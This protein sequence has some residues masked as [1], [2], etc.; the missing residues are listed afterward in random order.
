MNLLHR[1]LFTLSIC[2]LLAPSVWPQNFP[3]H[4]LRFVI[5]FAPG[6]PA[7]VSARTLAVKLTETLGQNIVIDNRPGGGGIVAAEI[8]ARARP[9][10]HTILLCSTSVMVINP[11]V[12]PDVPYD[13]LRDFAPVSLV[14]SSPYLLLTHA[15]FPATSVKELV[16]LAK[17]RP[18][19]LNFGSAGIGSTSHL[20]AEIFRSMAGIAMTHVPYKG[21]AL[22]ATDLMAGQLQVLFE[23]VSSALPNVNS[24]RLRALGISTLKRFA[25]T[26]QVPP[27]AESGVPGYQAATWQGVCAPAGTPK[28]VLAVLNRTVVDAARAPATVQRYAALGAEAVGSTPEE[29]TAFVKAEIPRWTKA[30]RDSGARPQ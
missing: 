9:D 4:P 11:I 15:T 7:D 28:P 3:S 22:A 26:P 8:V 29:F 2:A 23:S 14:S 20:V 19:T 24:G 16:A 30:I 5:P 10:G 12:T 21:S 6:G 17:A 25:L 18:G 27:I 1:L 13:A